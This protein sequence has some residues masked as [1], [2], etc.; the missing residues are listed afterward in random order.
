MADHASSNCRFHRN[1]PDRQDWTQQKNSQRCCIWMT[2]FIHSWGNFM[3]LP[4]MSSLSFMYTNG[5]QPAAR[6]CLFLLQPPCPPFKNR[7]MYVYTCFS[8]GLENE[9]APKKPNMCVY[10]KRKNQVKHKPGEPQ[11]FVRF[12]F[13]KQEPPLISQY[14]PYSSI[15]AS[16]NIFLYCIACCGLKGTVFTTLSMPQ[17]R[18][19][20]AILA[21][22][23]E[24]NMLALRPARRNL[25][26]RQ[27]IARI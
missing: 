10:L 15:E 24:S 9:S 14:R 19:Q 26:S 22:T 18:L 13:N 8:C 4:H 21:F 27:H 5:K 12:G 23:V 25:S 1:E 16:K 7:Y 6:G 2:Y 20:S 3:K 17:K 11:P